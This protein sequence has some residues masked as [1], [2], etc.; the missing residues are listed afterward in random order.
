MTARELVSPLLVPE[1]LRGTDAETR[2][3][4]SGSSHVRLLLHAPFSPGPDGEFGMDFLLPGLR[5][6]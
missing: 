1:V 3:T 5:R 6:C 4:H 2:T